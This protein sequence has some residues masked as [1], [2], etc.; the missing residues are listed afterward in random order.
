[1]HIR[2]T[3]PASDDLTQISDYIS[4]QSPSVARRVALAIWESVGSLERFPERG[5]V[6][7]KAG[8][9]ELILPDLPYIAVYR[10][11]NGIVQ[12]LRILHG[13]QKWP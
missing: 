7:R 6:G 5:R 11:R 9:R 12:V 2:W 3:R 10:V 1:M 4:Q 8:T 13:A